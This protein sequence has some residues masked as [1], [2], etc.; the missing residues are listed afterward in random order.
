M[1]STHGQ[2]HSIQRSQQHQIK[3]CSGR[4]FSTRLFLIRKLRFI[5]YNLYAPLH[6]SWEITWLLCSDDS[7]LEK[8]IRSTYTF[9]DRA[10]NCG[11]V[12]VA[13]AV[14]IFIVVTVDVA[15][16]VEQTVIMLDVTVFILQMPAS[17][18]SLTDIAGVGDGKSL[19]LLL[20]LLL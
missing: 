14:I 3:C 4:P 19:L 11:T 6:Q 16:I 18:S 2:Y 17:I 7:T 13:A 5:K 12:R 10:R 8:D 9:G 20:L 15:E 1:V